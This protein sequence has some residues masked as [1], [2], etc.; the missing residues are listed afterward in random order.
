MRQIVICLVVV[1]CMSGCELKDPCGNDEIYSNG[2]CVAC[3]SYPNHHINIEGFCVQDSIEAC[4]AGDVDCTAIEGVVSAEC[5]NGTCVV[6]AC[7]DSL[8]V[9][10]DRSACKACDK[11]EVLVYDRCVKCWDYGDH[12]HQPTPPAYRIAI[13]GGI[14]AGAAAIA[15]Y[16][17][18]FRHPE[19]HMHQGIW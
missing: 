9:N 18:P 7:K 14:D 12:Q 5:Q 11:D 19:V 15:R 3:Q 16:N 1:L 2:S 4:G 8:V 10:E 6:F 13:A 17:L